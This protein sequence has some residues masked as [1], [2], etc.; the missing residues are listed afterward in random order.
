VILSIFSGPWPIL[1]D[2]FSI[3][4]HFR[5]IGSCQSIPNKL[6]TWFS[7]FELDSELFGGPY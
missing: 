5:Q 3:F 1:G 7:Q 6:N 2:K 4:R